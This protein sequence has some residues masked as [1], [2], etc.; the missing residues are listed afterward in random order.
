M[1]SSVVHL[2]G[3]LLGGDPTNHDSYFGWKYELNPH[4][5]NP[6]GIVALHEDKVVGFRGYGPARWEVGESKAMQVLVPGDTFVDINHRQK[7]LSVAMGKL[8]TTD[9]AAT[10]QLFLNLSC[11]R[12]SLPGLRRIRRQSVFI[13]IWNARLD[14][15]PPRFKKAA[16]SGRGWNTVRGV[17]GRG[18]Q[19]LSDAG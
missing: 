10:H 6:L 11:T 7:G 17:R 19:R 14:V 15:V 3:E 1:R 5:E 9:Y 13:E 2:L 16:A 4:S 8:A 18:G 12:N